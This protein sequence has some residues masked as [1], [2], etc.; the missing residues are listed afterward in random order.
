MH[1]PLMFSI[2]IKAQDFSVG[3]CDLSV[4]SLYKEVA[5]IDGRGNM[6]SF[7]P[8]KEVY[9]RT[10]LSI[11][12]CGNPFPHQPTTLGSLPIID[13][14]NNCCDIQDTL[15][16]ENK[17]DVILFSLSL[18]DMT[19]NDQ[20]LTFS[21][22]I[23]I[24]DIIVGDCNIS[25]ENVY[26]KIAMNN[27]CGVVFTFSPNKVFGNTHLLINNN[28][29]GNTFSHEPKTLDAVN[30][31]STTNLEVYGRPNFFE[32][33]RY[34]SSYSSSFEIDARGNS[35]KD[36]HIDCKV[37]GAYFTATSHFEDH[38]LINHVGVMAYHCKD[39]GKGF[40]RK[41]GLKNHKH[42]K[43][44]SY[45]KCLKCGQKFKSICSLTKH[46]VLDH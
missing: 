40:S 37:C 6:F 38:M 29:C 42:R 7:K 46:Q 9:R 35:I 10:F 32:E 43:I 25:L 36:Y 44:T 11:D 3:R 20:R 16:Q 17:A 12:V 2:D 39:C 31:N 34:G 45:K 1:H 14:N 23:K 41:G 28:A 5:M 21:I 30:L 4:Q 19:K 33:N 15:Q 18:N 26:N 8:S 24:Q 22:E 27:G 13:R